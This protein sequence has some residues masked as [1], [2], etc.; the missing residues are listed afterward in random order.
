MEMKS[1]KAYNAMTW[2]LVTTRAVGPM[3]HRMT[4]HSDSKLRPQFMQAG[5]R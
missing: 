5:G 4:D 1:A 3:S 2:R